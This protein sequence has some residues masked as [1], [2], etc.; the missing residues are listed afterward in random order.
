MTKPEVTIVIPARNE[1]DIII[2][3]LKDISGK[4]SIPHNIIVVNDCSTDKT[5]RV[6][7]A[8]ARKRKNVRIVNNSSRTK[9]FSQV[10]RLG[11][12]KAKTEFCVPVMADLCDNPKTIIKMLNRIKKGYDIVCGSRYMSGGKKN[13][14]PFLQNNLSL[15][16]N[17]VM[18][19]IGFPT[20]DLTNAFKMYRRSKMNGVV[21]SRNGGVECSMEITL[22]AYF[23]GAKISDV[24]TIW[25]GRTKGISKF[26]VVQR[27]PRYWRAVK[28]GV[29]NKLRKLLGFRLIK[30]YA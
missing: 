19:L 23:A 21:F 7:K 6:V 5:E 16:L 27:A 14:G 25:K 18:Y 28:W 29:E 17:K 8:Y 2:S 12:E 10:I 3:T 26:K 9:G 30:F 1:E 22:Q 24:P 11:F 13:G 20:T 4:V 15:F